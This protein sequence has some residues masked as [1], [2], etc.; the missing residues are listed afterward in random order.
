[1]SRSFIPSTTT[2]VARAAGAIALAVTLVLV[3]PILLVQL[4][5]WPFPTV[6]PSWS[7]ISFAVETGSIDL[8]TWVKALALVAWVAWAQLAV[9]FVVELVAVA[10]GRSAGMIRGLGGAQWLAARTIA[11]ISLAA[12][13]LVKSS[14]VIAA[15]LPA[16][17]VPVKPVVAEPVSTMTNTGT[18]TAVVEKVAEVDRTKA[19][20]VV[21]R[22]DTLMSLAERHLGDADRWTE[23]REANVGRMMP[24]GTELTSSFTRIKPGWTLVLPADAVTHQVVEGDHLW[25]M[26]EEAL[27]AD[28]GR[29][30]TDAEITPYWSQVIDENLEALLPPE[31]PD[32]IFPGQE[33]TLPP[34]GHADPVVIVVGKDVPAPSGQKTPAEPTDL[35]PPADTAPTDTAPADTAR[36]DTA[37]PTNERTLDDAAGDTARLG[38]HGLELAGGTLLAA[39]LLGLLR[40][41]R[42]ARLASRRAGEAPPEIDE[43]LER[44]LAESGD[45]DA[46]RLLFHAVQT[47][48]ARSA[49]PGEP[50]PQPEVI[51]S[52]PDGLDVVMSA[53]EPEMP[54]PWT[55]RGD[56]YLYPAAALAELATGLDSSLS[57]APM[58]ASPALV[59]VADAVVVNLESIGVFSI[60]S[61]DSEAAVALIRS[62]LHELATGPARRSLDLRCSL[63]IAGAALHRSVRTEPIAELAAEIG[64]WL[65]RLDLTL[66]AA[67][68]ANAAALRNDSPTDPITPL[69]V[70]ASS[71][72][73]D[74]LEPILQRA[75][76]RRYP[77]AIVVDG[78][79]SANATAFIGRDGML[80]LAPHGHEAPAQQ[81]GV[82]VVDRVLESV[83]RIASAPLRRTIDPATDLSSWMLEQSDQPTIDPADVPSIFRPRSAHE[84]DAPA[85]LMPEQHSDLPTDPTL[86]IQVLGPV[87]VHSSRGPVTDVQASLISFLSVMGSATNEQAQQALW[88]HRR[89]DPERLTRLLTETRHA[90]G[91]D[92]LPERLD[93][94]LSL[95]GVRS[96]LDEARRALAD[97]DSCAG[98]GRIVHLARAVE[99]VRGRPF[100]GA[101]GRMWQWIEDHHSGIATQA[102]IV[103]SDAAIEVAE[104]AHRSGDTRRA[105]SAIDA[106]RLAAPLC[107]QL[108]ELDVAH[109]GADEATVEQ[110]LAT[111]EDAFEAATDGPTPVRDG[112][113]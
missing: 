58:W 35:H 19:S 98:A 73:L 99:L 38:D 34:T 30:A 55:A 16:F 22:R 2:A 109:C 101:T 108:V 76:S 57:G 112:E 83:N 36:T 87:E 103:L 12:T 82:D 18:A 42:I 45:D 1:M 3:V 90:I 88:P 92:V 10:R 43:E 107:Q 105:R 61:D 15:P 89:P 80:H 39:G 53:L 11:Q 74:A 59:T 106:G 63:D 78:R 33:L 79:C 4:V 66:G 37:P 65:D 14:T 75:R 96:D 94:T 41:V 81:L 111:F 40:R 95:E 46:A 69:I 44:S 56:A 84:L 26:A 86:S 31:D 48:A 72:D 102:A 6:V 67:G 28:L 52:S 68:A 51:M 91:R 25:A 13:V 54:A 9:A 113:R 17:A 24:D 77:L 50:M 60:E 8:R 100:D 20:T 97:A 29:E 64:R 62:M 93:G 7:E 85:T 47:L 71:D 27:E 104:A 32:L 70:F 110:V 49:R 23:L 5:G 21:G